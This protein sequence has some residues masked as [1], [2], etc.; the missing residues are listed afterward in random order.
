MLDWM[1]EIFTGYFFF[2]NFLKSHWDL[3]K[4]SSKNWIEIGVTPV[5]ACGVTFTQFSL[6]EVL[7]FSPTLD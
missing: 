4:R 2:H 1:I 3:S 5:M 6:Y 7:K